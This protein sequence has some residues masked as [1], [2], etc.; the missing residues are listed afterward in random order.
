MSGSGGLTKT[1]PGTLTL[2]Q[3]NALTGGT[4]INQGTVKLTGGGTIAGGALNIAAGATLDSSGVSKLI[5]TDGTVISGTGKIS[6]TLSISTNG[7][8]PPG[9]SPGNMPGVSQEWAA[10]GSYDW[11]MR[12]AA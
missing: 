10:G 6:G 2:T 8:I 7:H 4:W 1:G 5:I 3:T 11:E 12:D 9:N